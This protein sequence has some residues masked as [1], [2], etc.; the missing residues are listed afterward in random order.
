MRNFTHT[1][2]I[3][4]FVLFTCLCCLAQQT[5]PGQVA[6]DFL[7]AVPKSGRTN[8][9]TE[10]TLTWTE[11]RNN[12][13]FRNPPLYN[14]NQFRVVIARDKQLKDVILTEN[15][16]PATANVTPDPSDAP[17][18]I[19]SI[20]TSFTI[21]EKT[22]EP[23]TT[24]Y[25]QVYA[26][27]TPQGQ[28][29]SV[30]L[31]EPAKLQDNKPGPSFFITAIDPFLPLTRHNFSLQ[32]TVNSTDPTEGAQFSFL[33]TF[34][35]DTVFTTDFAF[36][37]DS[38][39]MRFSKNRGFV[40]FRP[41]VEGKL[42]SDTSTSEDAWRFSG[43]A[44]I[45]YNLIKIETNETDEH[46]RVRADT[47]LSAPRRFIDSLY[48][49]LGGALEGDQDFD[50]KKFTSRVYFSPSSRKLAIGTATGKPDSPV[51][52]MWRPSV[53]FNAGRT[54]KQGNSAET[55]KAIYRFVPQ[56]RFT[57]YTRA[58][59]RLLKIANSYLYAD[60]TFYY[61]PSDDVEK[62]HNFFTSGYELLFIKNFGFGLTYKN[63]E[64]APKFTR[65]NTFGGVLTVRFGPE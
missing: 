39:S 31:L 56:A 57:L 30:E 16:K 51:Q 60:N 54:I 24:Y 27:Y 11:D 22:L 62:K 23:G 37:W 3:G 13:S 28:Q 17:N 7:L 58:I 9:S 44:V 2:M 32:R 12:G 8:I 48:F 47:T 43:A 35:G 33:K 6:P 52:F 40:W 20:E 26:V 41:A 55:G 46:N 53:E 21:P 36:F 5:A 42:T 65:V 10:A 25:W 1:L 14:L 61:L 4:S 49:E 18:G 45:D 29:G 63:G 19:Q 38:P 59:S 50:T 34:N 64:I 15:V